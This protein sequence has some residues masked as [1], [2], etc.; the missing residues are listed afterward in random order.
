MNI[1]KPEVIVIDDD[2]INKA[3]NAIDSTEPTPEETLAAQLAKLVPFIR[4]A[5]NRG[6][7][8][9]KIRKKIRS[10]IPKLHYKRINALFESAAEHACNQHE[11]ADQADRLLGGAH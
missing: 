7:S 9:D 6:E 2:A 5:I 8:H 1:N 10:A 4:A 11:L 3:I